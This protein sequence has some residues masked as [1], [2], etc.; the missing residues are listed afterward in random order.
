[1]PCD[2]GSNVAFNLKITSIE[3]DLHIDDILPVIPKLLEL[4][5]ET[6]RYKFWLLT[7]D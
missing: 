1:L 7:M 2:P 6:K 3:L 4:L 5:P